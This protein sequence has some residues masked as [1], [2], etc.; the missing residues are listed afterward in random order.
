MDEYADKYFIYIKHF[1]L[2]LLGN[3]CQGNITLFKTISQ[4][5]YKC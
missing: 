5:I 3:T 4:R 1:Y 2:A